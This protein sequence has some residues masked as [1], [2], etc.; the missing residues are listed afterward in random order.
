MIPSWDHFAW[1]D[2][3]IYLQYFKVSVSILL[4]QQVGNVA[5]LIFIILAFTLVI[6]INPTFYKASWGLWVGAFLLP[7][8]GFLIGYGLAFIL[9]QGH[10]QCRAIGFETGSQ[11]AA[12]AFSI[13]VMSFATSPYFIF[14]IIYPVLY[15]LIIF[16]D[17]FI[18]LAIYWGYTKG[19]KRGNEVT[20]VKPVENGAANPAFEP[21]VNEPDKTRVEDIS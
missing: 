2:E 4:P 5:I 7:V 13:I 11:N 10:P 15:A 21:D 12:F 1:T 3:L 20:D 9:K 14:M 6:L 19:F 17:S 8:L 16:I 18:F